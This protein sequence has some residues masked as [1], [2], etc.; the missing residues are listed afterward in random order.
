MMLT[1]VSSFPSVP[2]YGKIS[3]SN[4]M[5]E[6]TFFNLIFICWIYIF[7]FLICFIDYAITVVPFPLPLDSPSALQPPSHQHGTHIF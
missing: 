7:I 6:P 3:S 2:L 1:V 5:L 4:F